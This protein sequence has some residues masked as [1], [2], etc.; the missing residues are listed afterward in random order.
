MSEKYCIK[1][2]RPCGTDV[3]FKRNLSRFT[4]SVHIRLALQ[5][6]DTDKESYIPGLYIPSK[7]EPPLADANVEARLM[8]FA[9]RFE[10]LTLHASKRCRNRF[11]LNPQ[12]YWVLRTLKSDRHFIVVL[13]DKNLG[14]AIMEQDEYIKRVL[15]DH[16]NDT[17]TYT[18]LSHDDAVSALKA[19]EKELKTLVASYDYLLSKAEK[20][21]FE[22]FYHLNHH[23]K[24][25]YITM[26]IHKNPM[27]T[28][29]IVS[30][31]GS[32][33][34]S[35]SI[36]LDFKMKSLIK[37]VPTYVQDSYQVLQEFKDL[38]ELPHNARLFTA[39]AVSMYTNINTEHGVQVFHEWLTDL[40]DDLH[41][42]IKKKVQ[43]WGQALLS[44]MLPFIMVVMKRLP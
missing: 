38:N 32:F 2:G 39:D 24:Q 3:M 33:I 15:D 42:F 26:K 41:F 18:R 1:R 25:F 12:Q 19:A 22:C 40:K 14:P 6:L 13:T 30:C 28:R 27:G 36:W 34:E 21:Y 20:T 37:F 8:E 35:F 10:R 9:E 44:S 31:C 11:N 16:L 5:H 29:P 7:F 17:S 43:R 23:M 4:R